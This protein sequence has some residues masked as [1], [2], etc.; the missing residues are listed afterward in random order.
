MIFEPIEIK[1]HRLANRITLAPLA[2]SSSESDGGPS[3]KSLEIY[4]R[5]ASSCAAMAVVEHHAVQLNGLIRP[6]QFRSDSDEVAAK[7]APVAKILKDAGMT[8]LVQINHGGA[9]IADPSVLDIEDYKNLSPSGVPVG[10]CWNNEKRKPNI[11]TKS[12]IGRIV[13]SFVEAAVRM[14]KTAGYDGIQIHACHGYL[15]GQFLSPL[16][17]RRDDSYGGSDSKR[18]RLLFEI[19]DAVRSTLPDTILAVRLG[20]A[21]YLPGEPMRGLS[22]DETVPAAKELASLGTDIIGISGNLCGFGINR[23]DEGYFAPYAL[24]IKEAVGDSCLVECTGGIKTASAAVRLLEN[25]CCDLIGVGRLVMK[26][27]GFGEKWRSEL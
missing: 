12:E 14:V 1:G 17:N 21:D 15:L 2:S 16:T 3:E 8:A 4:R 19:V 26:D 13:E 18:A 24:R 11:L 27:A 25:G 6:T 7:H 23:T 22:L 10:Q 5:F 9:N 20:A